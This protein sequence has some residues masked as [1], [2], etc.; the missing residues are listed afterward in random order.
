MNFSSTIWILVLPLATFLIT[1]LLGNKFP[2]RLSGILGTASLGIA[3]LLALNIAYSYFFIAGKTGDAYT[4]ITVM[5]YSWLTFSPSLSID[6]GILLDPISVMMLVVVTFV[7]FMVHLYSFSYMK[8]EPR[9]HVF[10]SFLSLFSFSMLGLVVASNIFQ[11]Y[12]F[13]ELVGVSS[14]LLIGFYYDKP[15]CFPFMQDHLISMRSFHGYL[16]RIHHTCK[17]LLRLLSWAPAH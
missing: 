6:M 5:K 1:G 3:A 17:P 10:F 15:S 8:D 12:I 4:A 2:K 13:W 14:F 9:Y 16:L 7:S 11:M